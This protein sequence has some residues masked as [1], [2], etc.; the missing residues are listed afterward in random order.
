M[1]EESDRKGAASGIPSFRRHTP[2]DP[3]DYRSRLAIGAHALLISLAAGA[4]TALLSGAL[5]AF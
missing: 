4:V 3:S 1:H 5:R 2:P